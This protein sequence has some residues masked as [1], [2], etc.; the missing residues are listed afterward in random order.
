MG[1]ISTTDARGL[2]TKKVVDVY[3]EMPAATSFLRSF[4]ADKTSN[5]KL[6]SIEVQRGTEK[7]AV[8]VAR[9]TEGNR[10]KFGLST[11][12]IF[13]PPYYREYFELTELALYDRLIGS[14]TIDASVF[15][16]LASEAAEKLSVL[17]A[18]IERAYEK[19]CAE[20]LETGIVTLN[21]GTNIDFKRKAGSLVDNSGTPWTT[22]STDVFAQ[23][24]AGCKFIRTEG[25]SQGAVF[26]MI[27][28]ETALAAFFN[29]T[30]VKDTGDL[31]RIDHMTI[32]EPQRNAVGATSHGQFSAGDYLVNLWSYPEFYDNASGVSTPYMHAKKAVILPET[33][34]FTMAFAAV[35]QLLTQGVAPQRGAY[36]VGE[37]TDQRKSSHVMD[38]KSAGV[39]IPVAVDQIYTMQ[40]VA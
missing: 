8:D 30:T 21:T 13:E 26:N 22:G 37:Y 31:R 15:S 1:S 5:S 4:F 28:G 2:F 25:K 16:E 17:R 18:K 14:E 20:A 29:N 6:V 10:N 3:K 7:V 40:V 9:G 11:E 34:R 36:H 39:A 35:P 23:V 24:Q 33:P 19:Q 12:K 38:I 27:V 32:R